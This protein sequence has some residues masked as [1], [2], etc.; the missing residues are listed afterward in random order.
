MHIGI[1]KL[2]LLTCIECVQKLKYNLNYLAF[3]FKDNIL[4][5]RYVS[6]MR[7]LNEKN[8]CPLN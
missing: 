1:K 4:I 5:I 6:K 2:F 8:K 7:S 3:K